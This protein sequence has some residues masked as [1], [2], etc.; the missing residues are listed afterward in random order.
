LAEALRDCWAGVPA[1]LSF[2]EVGVTDLL[3]ADLSLA[4]ATG[5]L[6]LLFF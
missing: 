2:A 1:V 4:S 3:D 6:L 5:V